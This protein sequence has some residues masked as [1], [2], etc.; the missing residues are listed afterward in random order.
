[1]IRR[2]ALV[3]ALFLIVSP[4][5]YAVPV[6]EIHE[7]IHPISKSLDKS[8]YHQDS[9]TLYQIESLSDGNIKAQVYSLKNGEEYV[10]KQVLTKNLLMEQSRYTSLGFVRVFLIADALYVI[11]KDSYMVFA[12]ED[13]GYL[14]HKT[15]KSFETKPF[16]KN[17]VT[18]KENEILSLDSGSAQQLWRFNNNSYEFELVAN[19]E[20][21][22]EGRDEDLTFV[23]DVDDQQ[24]INV[25]SFGIAISYQLDFELNTISVNYK[26]ENDHRFS[27]ILDF[28]TYHSDLN[29]FFRKDR[30]EATFFRLDAHGEL[31]ILAQHATEDADIEFNSELSSY[32]E[33][34]DGEISKVNIDW[35]TNSIV[36]NTLNFNNNEF[37]LS[38]SQPSVI[39]KPI[40]V[41]IITESMISIIREDPIHRHMI[42]MIDKPYNVSE[43]A[44]NFAE[45]DRLPANLSLKDFDHKTS[46]L[47][48]GTTRTVNGEAQYR[49]PR[50]EDSIYLW[51]Y[52]SNSESWK[53]IDQFTFN[54]AP[55]SGTF[56]SY[57]YAGRIKN[58]FYFVSYKSMESTIELVQVSLENGAFVQHPGK[59]IS[60]L[61][62]TR[63]M[64]QSVIL[65]DNHLAL[66]FSSQLHPEIS[67]CTIEDNG[68]IN[69][70]QSKNLLEKFDF[71]HLAE[72]Y[73]FFKLDNLGSFL[74]ADTGI[75]LYSEPVGNFLLS[76]NEQKREFELDQ[77]FDT[78][79]VSSLSYNRVDS[80]EFAYATKTKDDLYIAHDDIYHYS[81]NDNT[82][83]WE[84]SGLVFDKSF[85]RLL[86]SSQWDYSSTENDDYLLL[87]SG[88]RVYINHNNKRWVPFLRSELPN[89][90]TSGEQYFYHQSESLG[91]YVTSYGEFTAFDISGSFPSINASGTQLFRAGPVNVLQDE[92]FKFDL[93]HDFI[94]PS[95]LHFEGLPN[96]FSF[97]GTKITG[98][99]TNEHIFPYPDSATQIASINIYF[100]S[101]SQDDGEHKITIIP[102]NV[103]DTPELYQTID[104][105]YLSNGDSF[106]LDLP[107]YIRD[108]DRDVISYSYQGLPT[109]LNGD[110]Q[111]YISGTIEEFGDF[112]LTVVATDPSGASLEVEIL[113]VSNKKGKENTADSSGSFNVYL[114][115][116]L[117][118]LVCRRN[119]YLCRLRVNS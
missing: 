83:L 11:G 18:L 46:Q 100:T 80:V 3:W 31:S 113:M 8:F 115:A 58:N 102:I 29:V 47:L 116:L 53:F 69:G 21:R 96:G 28:Q 97:D 7:T 62:G 101:D 90:Y 72:G 60:S 114:I 13:E 15:T 61:N 12:V 68:T 24:I 70:C 23:Y 44:L 6:Y 112:N 30:N 94:N 91:F 52:D 108:P 26:A 105:I 117:G 42:A 107:E 10:L 89:K 43:Y 86:K 67:T 32:I 71:Q 17:W 98:Q 33:K 36:K 88:E 20:G 14:T 50:Y 74:F 75:H 65:S 110:G 49:A 81:W 25:S 57:T 54:Y 79:A 45:F 111:G 118:F 34:V 84:S 77:V 19:L 37:Y 22:L 41:N 82:S 59:P 27:G 103:N 1:M 78:R 16:W 66:L 9:E 95:N 93:S 63:S 64:A 92:Q 5:L 76:F 2:L 48:L 4:Y 119:G 38:K 99:L 104:T 51:E 35:A 109:G 85:S 56:H 40:L 106:T 55:I 87:R 73:R 39:S